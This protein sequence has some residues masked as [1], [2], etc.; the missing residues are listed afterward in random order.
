MNV[1]ILSGIFLC[2]TIFCQSNLSTHNQNDMSCDQPMPRGQKVTVREAFDAVHTY[3]K[4]GKKVNEIYQK[5]QK[6]AT[7]RASNILKIP[8]LAEFVS[9]R[10][11]DLTSEIGNVP[12][13]AAKAVIEVFLGDNEKLRERVKAEFKKCDCKHC[14]PPKKKKHGKEVD[15]KATR[16]FIVLSEAPESISA[17]EA[18]RKGPAGRTLLRE[19]RSGTMFWQAVANAGAYIQTKE[20]MKAW[21][22]FATADKEKASTLKGLSGVMFAN[23]GSFL[24]LYGKALNDHESLADGIVFLANS[25]GGCSPENTARRSNI[26]D[27][28]FQTKFGKAAGRVSIRDGISDRVIKAIIKGDR[29]ELKAVLDDVITLKFAAKILGNV[30]T[31]SK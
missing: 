4:W 5:L 7:K 22:C 14:N 10:T 17:M 16:D 12:Q 26:V 27:I 15:D 29:E 28:M 25:L 8:Q 18:L 3:L 23:N 6:G 24:K 20:D 9:Q 30:I 31:R 21:W 11:I 13:Q 19:V 1:R 2:L